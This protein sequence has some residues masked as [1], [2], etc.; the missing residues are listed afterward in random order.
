M[1]ATFSQMHYP[2]LLFCSFW[3]LHGCMNDRDGDQLTFLS[4]LITGADCSDDLHARRHD[5]RQTGGAGIQVRQVSRRLDYV[6]ICAR[7]AELVMIFQ[8]LSLSYTTRW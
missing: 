2:H 4:V 5:S 3:L 7:A 8:Q 6:F 1:N